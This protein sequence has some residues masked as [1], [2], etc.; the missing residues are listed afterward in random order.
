MRY[1]TIDGKQFSHLV[2]GT[3]NYG[4]VLSEKESFEILDLFYSHGGRV[5]DT[6][7]LYTDGESEKIVGKWLKSNNLYDEVIIIVKG[8]YSDAGDPSRITSKDLKEDIAL[9]QDALQLNSFDFYLYHRDDLT[10]TSKELIS[11]ADDY[12]ADGTIKNLGVSNWSAARIEEVA[13]LV[14]M[15]EIQWSLAQTTPKLL[16]DESLVVMNEEE[17]K[18]YEQSQLPVLAY[19]SQAKG[20]FS[21]N[22]ASLSEKSKSR[23][24]HEHNITK[25]AKVEQ[26]AIKKKCS[27][28]A[29]ALAYLLDNTLNAFPIIG[30]TKKEQLIDSLSVVDVELTKEEIAFL[31]GE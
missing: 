24:Y 9:S 25:R 31:D 10:R 17:F 1:K 29:I 21:K 14:K 22:I 11:L 8:V 26:L 28:A 27:I 5:I 2:L 3:N 13:S 20:F 6:A 16:N 12:L 4:T 23:F 7:R 15:S 19:G 30:A 18:W